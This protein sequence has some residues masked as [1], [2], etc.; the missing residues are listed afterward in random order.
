MSP[1]DQYVI[2]D[3]PDHSE[4]A[5]W[6]QPRPVKELI[7]DAVLDVSDSE[8]TDLPP[9]EESV[10]HDALRSLFGEQATNS[11]TFQLEDCEVT[12]HSSGT[13]DVERVT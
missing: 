8:A 10:D 4:E 5:T 11:L 1:H 6:I 12:V 2:P 7:F 13:V 9:L 3:R